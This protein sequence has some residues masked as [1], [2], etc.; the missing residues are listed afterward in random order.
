MRFFP[1]HPNLEIIKQ[2]NGIII[3]LL[4]IETIEHNNK[5]LKNRAKI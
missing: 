3:V 1:F 2:M 4:Q 5:I